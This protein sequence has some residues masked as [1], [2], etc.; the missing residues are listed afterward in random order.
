VD[1]WEDFDVELLYKFYN[2]FL[3]VAHPDKGDREPLSDWLKLLS[4][5]VRDNPETEDFHIL[6]ALNYP[7]T[8]SMSTVNMKP[9]ILGGLV[10]KFSSNTNCG[11]ITFLSVA[12]QYG[13]VMAK[14]LGA[15]LDSTR[16]QISRPFFHLLLLGD[17][18]SHIQH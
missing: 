12:P 5:Q 16:C 10:F 3:V 18:C 2:N 6:L 15:R 7:R 13:V 11:L 17:I 9:N 14:A 1:L 4:P 8:A